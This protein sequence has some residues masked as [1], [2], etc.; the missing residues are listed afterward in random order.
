MEIRAGQKSTYVRT[1]TEEDVK[2]FGELSG[3]KGI[4]HIKPDGLGRIMVQGLLTAT[5][6]TKLGGDINYIARD[7]IAHFLKPVYVGDRVKCDAV[8]TRVDED[9]RF[10][11]MSI[12]MNCVNQTDEEVMTMETNGVVRK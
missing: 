5:I 9:A 10:Y 1:F 12:K 2:V 4:H 6:P 7:M 3:D 8:I 11:R